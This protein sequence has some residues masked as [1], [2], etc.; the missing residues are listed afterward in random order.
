M[1]VVRNYY[2]LLF[3]KYL[4]IS[5]PWVRS[6]TNIFSN[7]HTTWRVN[8]IPT[9]QRKKWMCREE[10]YLA[11]DLAGVKIPVNDGK[12]FSEIIPAKDK[13]G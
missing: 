11:W 6:P 3:I 13:F 5:N 4:Q 1:S 8:I 9:F 10:K 7:P 2:Q 12:I